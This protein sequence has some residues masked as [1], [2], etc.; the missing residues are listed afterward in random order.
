MAK[1]DADKLLSKVTEGEVL[2]AKEDL[3]DLFN[4]E[5]KSRD[6]YF[7][8]LRRFEGSE[9]ETIKWLTDQTEDFCT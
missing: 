5:V 8:E 9:F 6:V 4:M 3:I 2:K 1:F 7:Q